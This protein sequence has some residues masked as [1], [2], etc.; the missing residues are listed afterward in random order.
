MSRVIGPGEQPL[1]ARELSSS[2]WADFESLFRKYHGVQAGCWCMFYHRE[3]PTG[4]LQSTSRQEANR[5]DHHALL[6]K[7][8]AHGIL[9]YRGAQPIGWCQFGRR[10]DLPRVE[11]GRK[12]KSIASRLGPPPAWRITCFFVDRPFRRSGVARFALHAALDA[13]RRNGG[14]IVEGYPSTHAGAVA[15]WFGS[16]GMF[17]REGFAV[18]RPFGQS[19][20]LVRREVR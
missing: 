14:G 8:H 16:I 9:V 17:E 1:D 10:A 2:T 13:I 20:V 4:P 19:N 18:V 6:L 5:R 11:R 15:T 12:Y 3:G 7:G